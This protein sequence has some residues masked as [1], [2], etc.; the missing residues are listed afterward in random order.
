MAFFDSSVPSLQKRRKVTGESH[1]EERPDTK[2][3]DIVD[4]NP[5][6]ALDASRRKFEASPLPRAWPIIGEYVD[7]SGKCS[8]LLWWKHDPP[9]ATLRQI[10]FPPDETAVG[11]TP[12]TLDEELA[13]IA[14]MNNRI[15][16][17]LKDSGTAW[18]RRLA[19]SLCASGVARTHERSEPANDL[20]IPR[21]V[22]APLSFAFPLR[23]AESLQE[24][25]KHYSKRFA[26]SCVL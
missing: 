9:A 15:D 23:C 7:S 25:W 3:E 10:C 12:Y 14:L 20:A 8:R 17:G 4:Y 5:L 16:L 6:A 21:A 26:V 2:Q 18:W 24:K 22:C 11:S 1:V 19:W 13:F